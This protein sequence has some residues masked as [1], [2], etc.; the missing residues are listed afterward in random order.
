MKPAHI[1]LISLLIDYLTVNEC[2]DL[3]LEEYL[4]LNGIRYPEKE[5]HELT[6]AVQER[7]SFHE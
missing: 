1:K 2:K 7:L 6:L 5:M 3:T 4:C